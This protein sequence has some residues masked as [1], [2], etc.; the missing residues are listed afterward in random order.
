[1]RARLTEWMQTILYPEVEK[2]NNIQILFQ[3]NLMRLTPWN[4]A[5]KVWLAFL[6]VS[7][8]LVQHH[9][10]RKIHSS[11]FATFSACILQSDHTDNWSYPKHSMPFYNFA[12][13]LD[14]ICNAWWPSSSRPS[15]L[16]FTI[17]VPSSLLFYYHASPVQIWEKSDNFVTSWQPSQ[18]FLDTSI[19][20]HIPQYCWI[21]KDVNC[22]NRKVWT[23]TLPKAMYLWIFP[24]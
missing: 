19:F 14:P 6:E 22:E 21:F 2:E 20:T 8:W 3:N 4:S 10:T 23:W 24:K 1:M 13:A 11:P 17:T 18:H 7:E 16:R 12:L 9:S 15:E 5:S